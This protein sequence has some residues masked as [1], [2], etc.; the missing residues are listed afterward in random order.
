MPEQMTASHGSVT[1]SY[2]L[3][4][5]PAQHNDNEFNSRFARQASLGVEV[6]INLS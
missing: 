6:D 3:M 4:G 2:G 5:T 1:G